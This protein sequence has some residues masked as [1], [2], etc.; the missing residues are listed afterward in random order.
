MKRLIEFDLQEGGAIVVEVDEP[1][2]E[3]GFELTARP[4]EIVAKT[5]QTFENLL[6]RIRPA[7]SAI[8]GKLRALSDAPDEMT[9]EFGLK[10]SAEAGAV[11]AAASAEANYKVTLSWKREQ[12]VK[13]RSL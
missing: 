12:S 3:G 11:I 1:E 9:V 13:D 6:D 4:G 10:M 5:G 8:I 7:A 2:P